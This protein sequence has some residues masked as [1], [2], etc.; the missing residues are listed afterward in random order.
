[1]EITEN[2]IKGFRAKARY[3]LVSGLRM[4]ARYMLGGTLEYLE[5]TWQVSLPDFFWNN[6]PI[7]ADDEWNGSTYPTRAWL[8]EFNKNNDF[9]RLAHKALVLLRETFAVEQA[10]LLWKNQDS[11]GVIPVALLGLPDIVARHLL[12]G[13]GLPLEEMALLA[14]NVQL[15]DKGVIREYPYLA[16][17]I[18]SGSDNTNTFVTIP[19]KV[20]GEIIGL[21]VINHWNPDESHCKEAL[22]NSLHLF[23]TVISLGLKFIQ[24]NKIKQ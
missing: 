6:Q 22:H 16:S 4:K 20:G 3:S 15:N 9:Y 8:Y 2:T 17:C 19:L 7:L 1:M 5:P 11:T 10:V 18:A 13:A 21:I 24:Q 12:L 14:R 23:G